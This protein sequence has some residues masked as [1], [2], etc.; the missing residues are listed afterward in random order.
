MGFS[1]NKLLSSLF[2]NKAD[3]DIKEIRPIVEQILAVEPDIQ[4][5]T[6]D[7][8]RAKVDEIKAFLQDSK[9]RHRQ[10]PTYL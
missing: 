3:R 10:A 7:E 9:H 2:G 8:L 6:N 1:L 5:L 4:K